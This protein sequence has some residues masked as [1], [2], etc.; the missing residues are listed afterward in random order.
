MY[1]LITM[2]SLSAYVNQL[3]IH[4]IHLPRDLHNTGSHLTSVKNIIVSRCIIWTCGRNTVEMFEKAANG[5][6]VQ[7]PVLDQ[8]NCLLCGRIDKMKLIGA[9]PGLLAGSLA[10]GYLHVFP[11]LGR[12]V[13]RLADLRNALG[14]FLPRLEL[15]R[16]KGKKKKKK[17][18]HEAKLR[19]LIF[20]G[21]SKPPRGIN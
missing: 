12:E 10:P 5:S 17:Q 13:S 4:V 16:K 8:E 21:V 20:E 2:T 1:P 3:E 7:R 19:N 9:F 6:V 14:S 11:G 15:F 18:D